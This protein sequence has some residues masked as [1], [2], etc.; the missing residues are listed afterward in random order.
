MESQSDRQARRLALCGLLA[1]FLWLCS[2]CTAVAP[3][4]PVVLPPEPPA[5]RLYDEPEPLQA[6][7]LQVSERDL[8]TLLE[9][10]ELWQAWGAVVKKRIYGEA[11]KPGE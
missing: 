5:P 6:G 11:K 3:A 4:P 10:L 8:N 1:L 2:A 9:T 7:Y